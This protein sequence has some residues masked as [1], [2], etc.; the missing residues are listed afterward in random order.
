MGGAIA[1]SLLPGSSLFAV[2]F[3]VP[4]AILIGTSF[5]RWDGYSI[6]F[7]GLSNYQGILSDPVFWKAVTNTGVFAAAAVFVQVPIGVIVGIILSHHLPG[8]KIF[9]T[10]LFLPAMISGAAMALVFSA[11]Y[12]ARYGLLNQI[13]EG[14]GLQGHDWVFDPATSRIAVVGTYVFFIGM[15]MILVMAEITAIP[16]DI[17]EA[18]TIDGVSPI[19]QELFITLPLLRNVTGTLVLLALLW[20]LSFFDTVFLLT[21][22]GP[23]DTTVT[24]P[25]YAYRQYI[26]GHWGYVNA[27]GAILISVGLAL[28]VAIRRAFRIGERD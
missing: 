15:A 19:K 14:V 20:S 7:V 10:I 18:A 27:V 25:L 8:W 1:L 5:T 23:A 26:S 17:Y 13:L 21:A 3:L 6:A 4:I 24:I 11:V 16:K 28:I 9:R 2:F 22:G 12:N